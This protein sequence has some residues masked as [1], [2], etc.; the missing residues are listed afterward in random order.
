MS[1]RW[2]L[3]FLQLAL[4]HARMSKDP[5][6]RV[7]A[8][9]VGPDNEIRSVG[10]N[11]FP[12]R[13]A[14]SPER[15]NNREEKLKLVVHGEMNAILAA[16]RVGVSVN[17]CVMYVAA[18]DA[19]SGKVWGGNPCTRCT[20]EVI[21]AGIKRVVSWP[22]YTVPFQWREDVRYARNLLIEADVAITDIPLSRA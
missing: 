16:A 5:S 12:R 21:Q 6:T 19:I 8:V 20:V 1:L 22:I 4:D 9:I 10:F 11:G 13:I 2:D 14:D 3:H 17:G 15:L 7:G 18:T